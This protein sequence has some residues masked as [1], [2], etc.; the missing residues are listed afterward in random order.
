MYVKEDLWCPR[1]RRIVLSSF[2]RSCTGSG[3]R[4]LSM[5]GFSVC[6]SAG[7]HF[8]SC[9]HLRYDSYLAGG[10]SQVATFARLSDSFDSYA[11]SLRMLADFSLKA[12]ARGS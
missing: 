12:V 9:L 4:F 11:A 10:P 2:I 6:P 3:N 8:P 5:T 7:C 1:R